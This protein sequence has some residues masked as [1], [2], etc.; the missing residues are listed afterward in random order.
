[1]G[2]GGGGGGGGGYKNIQPVT[3]Q[4][5]FFFWTSPLTVLLVN[6]PTDLK[7]AFSA[8]RICTVEAGYLARLVRLP[9]WEIKRA[10]TYN[11]Q[12]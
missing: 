3:P 4:W 2:A 7:S 8:P 12:N 9:A 1:M 5:G 10:P 11:M 6:T